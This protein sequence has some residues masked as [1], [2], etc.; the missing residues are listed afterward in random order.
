MALSGSH[1]LKR[2]CGQWWADFRPEFL[3]LGLDVVQRLCNLWVLKQRDFSGRKVWNAYSSHP[4]IFSLGLTQKRFQQRGKVGNVG[5]WLYLVPLSPEQ[6]ARIPY[7]ANTST[8]LV[9]Q[10]MQRKGS[11]IQNQMAMALAQVLPLNYRRDM[12]SEL[13]F[14]VCRMGLYEHQYQRTVKKY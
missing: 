6:R 12:N 11:R 7:L 2:R 4:G 3:W 9:M 10:S 1:G 14:L 5:T 13:H 8:S